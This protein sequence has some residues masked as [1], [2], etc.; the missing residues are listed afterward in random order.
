MVGR[1]INDKD[2]DTLIK[3]ENTLTYSKNSNNVQRN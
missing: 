1:I 3:K 2:V